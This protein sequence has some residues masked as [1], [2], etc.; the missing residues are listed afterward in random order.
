MNRPHLDAGFSFL[1]AHRA[2]LA[3]PGVATSL[4]EGLAKTRKLVTKKD[5]KLVYGIPYSFT[6]IARLEAAGQFP[7]KG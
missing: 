4:T 1:Y 3:S 2:P 5:L 7:K 6:R